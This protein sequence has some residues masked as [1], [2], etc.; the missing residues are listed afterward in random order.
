MELSSVYIRTLYLKKTC[1]A[2]ISLQPNEITSVVKLPLPLLGFTSK[3][4]KNM[5]YDLDVM[6]IQ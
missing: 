2:M 1:T 3:Q 5:N 6:M 4:N